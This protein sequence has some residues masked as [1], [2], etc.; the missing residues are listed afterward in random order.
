MKTEVP[1]RHFRL[2]CRNHPELR[3]LTKSIA[4]SSRPTQNDPR[5]G[6]FNNSRNIFFNGTILVD[7]S[8]SYHG[9]ECSCNAS[10]LV[11]APEETGIDET[12]T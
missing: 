8:C 1:M 6:Y 12:E 11:L 10:Y 3:W 9:A 5:A 4:W 2:T 7:G